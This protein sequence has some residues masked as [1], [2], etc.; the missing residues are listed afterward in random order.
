[1]IP[2]SFLFL[3]AV[4]QRFQIKLSIVQTFP[5]ECLRQGKERKEII[6]ACVG[7]GSTFVPDISDY[8]STVQ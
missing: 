4:E 5:Q 2:S 6:Y 7:S 3:S 1:M 8:S